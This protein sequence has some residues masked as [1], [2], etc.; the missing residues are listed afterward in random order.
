LILA[1]GFNGFNPMSDG[2]IV[3][4]LVVRQNIMVEERERGGRKEGER[5]R[6]GERERGKGGRKGER[7]KDGEREREKE[8]EGR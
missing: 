6:E 1:Y 3:S 5:G 7:E 2:F 4:G 8:R